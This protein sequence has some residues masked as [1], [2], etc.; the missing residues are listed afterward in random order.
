MRRCSCCGGGRRQGFVED[1]FW[2][3]ELLKGGRTEAITSSIAVR[4]IGGCGEFEEASTHRDSDRDT[5]LSSQSG[6]RLDRDKGVAGDKDTACG[7]LLALKR[8]LSTSDPQIEIH[9]SLQIPSLPRVRAAEA[10][11]AVLLARA[12]AREAVESVSLLEGEAV[13]ESNGAKAKGKV[14]RLVGRDARALGRHGE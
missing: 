10:D 5:P 3:A 11:R 14:T 2:D 13:G 8:T 12:R 4:Y 9:V 1:V 7:H 6:H